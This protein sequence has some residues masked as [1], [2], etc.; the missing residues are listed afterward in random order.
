MDL[1]YTYRISRTGNRRQILPFVDLIGNDRQISLAGIE[2]FEYFFVAF[3][4]HPPIMSEGL[5]ENKVIKHG[6]CLY[7]PYT[8]CHCLNHHPPLKYPEALTS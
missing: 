2:D 3:W 8:Y 5:Y 4:R 6:P 7:C 1:V